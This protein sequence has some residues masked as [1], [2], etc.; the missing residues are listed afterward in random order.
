MVRFA[1]VLAI[2][3]MV[4]PAA[5]QTV[6]MPIQYSWTAPTTGSV[7]HHYVVQKSEAAGTWTAV[8]T[9]TTTT[10]VL[11]AT[12]GV[13]VQVRV[14]GV[15]AQSRTGAWSNPSD[16]LTPD[17]GPPGQPGTPVIVP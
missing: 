7:V 3:L 11:T 1:F 4:A 5:A 2:L 12:V 15:D 9:S 13:A 8:G 16:A 14:A 17:A 10:F 6:T